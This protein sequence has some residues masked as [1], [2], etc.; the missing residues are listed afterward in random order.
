M[1][2]EEH[3]QIRYFKGTASPEER[4]LME[5]WL[6][7]NSKNEAVYATTLR[8]W[9]HAAN[10]ERFRDIDPAADLAQLKRKR[11]A[12]GVEASAKRMPPRWLIA[13]A[14]VL[15]IVFA[16]IWFVNQPVKWTSIT[17]A[18]S[19]SVQ[20]KDGSRVWL[21]RGSSISYPETFSG[22]ERQLS[23]AGEAYFDIAPNPERPFVIEAGN[24]RIQVVGTAFQVSAYDHLDKVELVVTEGRV[25]FSA[26]NSRQTFLAI[27]AGQQALLAANGAI[28]MLP[29]ASPNALA[30]QTGRLEFDATPIT[31]AMTQLERHFDCQFNWP[32]TKR[33]EN[34]TLTSVWENASLD[35]VLEDLTET[36][37]LISQRKGK[38]IMILQICV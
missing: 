2:P 7:A 22:P 8:I 29:K 33:P 31:E 37:G 5:D 36:H 11:E 24:A 6:K 38:K 25:Y 20:L 14:I 23:L 4:T 16:G 1:I 13:A 26:Q 21:N 28:Q 3:I 27:E 15:L 9:Q 19:T 12:K 17:Y 18:Q 34:C 30:W 35:E 32:D 10:A